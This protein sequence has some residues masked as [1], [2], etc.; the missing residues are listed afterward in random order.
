MSITIEQD[1]GCAIAVHNQITPGAKERVK[2][3]I[4]RHQQHLA[5]Q[6]DQRFDHGQCVEHGSTRLADGERQRF[7]QTQCMLDTACDR[8]ID[9]LVKGGIGHHNMGN[10]CQRFGRNL[11]TQ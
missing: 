10:L 4:R 1:G 2:P 5:A 6:A 8:F 7:G 11:L 3:F 9:A